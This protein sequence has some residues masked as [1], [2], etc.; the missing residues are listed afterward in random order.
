MPEFRG[1]RA[2]ALVVLAYGAGTVS[3]QDFALDEQPVEVEVINIGALTLASP[4]P[5]Q[6]A[7]L[8]PRPHLPHEQNAESAGSASVLLGD[9][10]FNSGTN[11]ANAYTSLW[12]RIRA[13]YGMQD[14]DS[15][16]V[17]DWE[18]WY[19]SRPDY[20]ARMVARA[21]RYL[22]YI[23]EEVEKRG[24]PAEIALLPMIESAYNPNAYSTSH[25]SGIW[26][27]IPSTGKLYGLRQTW[28]QDERR[29]VLAATRAALDYLEKLYAMFGSWELALASYNWGEGAV[30]RAVQRNEARGLGT[31]YLSLDMPAETRNYI[32]KLMAVKNI[33]TRPESYGLTLA[34]VQNQPYFAV[35]TTDRHIDVKLAAK[36]AEMPVEEFQALNPSHNRPVIRADSSQP[37]LLPADRADIFQTKLQTYGESLTTWQSYTIEKGERIERIAQRFG[38][39]LSRLKEING[40]PARLRNLVGLTILVPAAGDRPGGDIAAAGFAAS[41]VAPVVGPAAVAAQAAKHVVKAGETLAG[42][43]RR[44][45]LSVAQLAAANGIRNGK[46]RAGQ[47]LDLGVAGKRVAATSKQAP[48]AKRSAAPRRAAA[49]TATTT[50]RSTGPNTR[51]G[52]TG[53]SGAHVAKNATAKD[54]ARVTE[55]DQT[56][57]QVAKDSAGPVPAARVSTDRTRLDEHDKANARAAADDKDRTRVALARRSD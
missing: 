37:I 8:L 41:V 42:I 18:N 48:A 24:M 5:A 2:L 26:Q 56:R 50:A 21:E 34:E 55:D 40:I 22:Y 47:S 13:S 36:L 43:A 3:A 28:W 32:P 44:Y 29:D 1:I 49:D 14:L 17:K 51:G 25:A 10:P 4:T 20:V 7:L 30:S 11:A 38:I 35:V 31:D 23:V 54:R 16:L 57:S 12:E 52:A 19:A 27:F 39:A 53:K 33:I 46:I 9:I 45:Q 6:P 15:P